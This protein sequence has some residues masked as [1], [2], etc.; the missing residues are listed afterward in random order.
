MHMCIYVY[1]NTYMCIC[2][3]TFGKA[4]N[5][6]GNSSGVDDGLASG[7]GLGREHLAR[8]LRLLKVASVVP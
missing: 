3:H 2:S 8:P 4:R 6:G 1:M 7:V 5:L